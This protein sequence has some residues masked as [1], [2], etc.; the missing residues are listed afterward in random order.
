ME[1]L[2][3][4]LVWCTKYRYKLLSVR[5]A[6]ALR[7]YLVYRQTKWEYKII[8]LATE[9]DHVHLLFEIKSSQVDLNRLVKRLKGGSSSVLRKKFSSLMAYPNLW[10]PSHFLDT[11]GNVSERT[12]SNYIASQGI[13]E[14]EAVIR[15][16]KCKVGKLNRGKQRQ[17]NAWL[18][19]I[20]VRPKGLQQLN[21]KP[22][23]PDRVWLRNDLIALNG[24][25][26]KLPGGNGWK[27]IWIPLLAPNLPNG[28][29]KDSYLRWHKDQL[30]AYLAIEQG[31]TIKNVEKPLIG[32]D[33]GVSN[34]LAGV[35]LKDGVVKDTWIA[36]RQ[37]KKT[38]YNRHKRSDKLR[39][40][41]KTAIGK[42][43]AKATRRLENELHCITK[44]IIKKAKEYNAT[45]VVGNLRGVRK[46]W[47][48]SERK[49]NKNFRRKAVSTPY[50]KI[51]GQIWYKA[52]IEGIQVVFQN[53]HYT[54]QRCSR[55]GEI[56]K[57]SGNE[58][59]CKCGYRQ[60]SD[61]NG[62]INIALAYRLGGSRM[63]VSGA[64]RVLFSSSNVT[65]GGHRANRPEPVRRLSTGSLRF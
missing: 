3:F 9:S 51:M 32:V 43:V 60:H 39:K 56:G 61:W 21:G 52:T 27:T 37:Y 12:I 28:R 64:A 65:A 6:E 5:I 8:S 17:V 24:D 16:F 36:G 48:K 13:E 44:E 2:R 33:L 26:L 25:W 54:S 34:M 47:D 49:R 18:K 41:G 55:C 45:I 14:T 10:T 7:E 58:F 57:R 40:S 59:V 15:T 1:K 35:V 46:T 53:E 62:A 42:R 19:D 22:N 29:L 50:A 63:S 30:W 31:I 4:H 38:F 11:V 23:L 20:R